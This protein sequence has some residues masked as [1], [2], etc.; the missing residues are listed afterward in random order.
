M[1]TSP[2]AWQ[3]LIDE[4]RTVGDVIKS[5]SVNPQTRQGSVTERP[6]W[7]RWSYAAWRARQDYL[8]RGGLWWGPA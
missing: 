1:L 8:M 6:R 2:L 5:W 3:P 4:R 7:G